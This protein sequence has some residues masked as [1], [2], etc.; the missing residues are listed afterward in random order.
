MEMEILIGSETMAAVDG[1]F[2]F[3]SRFWTPHDSLYR[4]SFTKVVLFDRVEAA[5]AIRS[6]QIGR[7][8]LN[9]LLILLEPWLFWVVW[10][11]VYLTLMLRFPLPNV[12]SCTWKNRKIG[13]AHPCDC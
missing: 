7:W 12:F 10:K 13:F 11:L 1:F 4:G 6:D 9:S 5:P 2:L 8:S 3:V